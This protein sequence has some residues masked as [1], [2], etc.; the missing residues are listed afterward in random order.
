MK[1]GSR[2][3]RVLESGAFAVTAELGPPK[4][5]DLGVVETKMGLLDG[6]CDAVNI[7]DNQT[8]IV[9]LSSVATCAVLCRSGMEPVMQMTCRDR[10]R[11][12]I[13]AD[14]FGAVALGVRNLLCLTGDHQCF[15]NHPTAKNVYDLDSIQLIQMVAQMR[16][17]GLNAGGEAIAGPMPLFIGGAANPFGDPFAFRVT[18]LAKKVA[19]GADFIQTQ[20][21]FDLP[22]FRAFMRQAVDLGLHERTHILAGVMPLKSAG[23]ARYINNNVAGIS[24]PDEIVKRM[25]DAGKGKKAQAEGIR[26]CAETIQQVREIEGVHGVHIMAVE[27]EEAIQE[28]TSL[29]G[30]LP[31]PVPAD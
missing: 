29:A 23:A 10:N 8:A 30:L 2:L 16:D 17:T 20:C 22:R 1:S 26:L 6:V 15:G 9:R 28:I 11:L 21:I 4:G 12:A 24:V 18:R 13:Q 19:A 27:W 31:R 25:A 5:P 14:L 7:T 3:E